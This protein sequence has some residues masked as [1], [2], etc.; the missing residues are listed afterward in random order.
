MVHKFLKL[1]NCSAVCSFGSYFLI[2][3]VDPW[4]A[5]HATESSGEDSQ[6]W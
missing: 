4:P 2:I 5:K 1:A 3:V 6:A